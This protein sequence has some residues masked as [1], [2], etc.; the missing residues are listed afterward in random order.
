M[1]RC[2]PG[3]VNTHGKYLLAEVQTGGP[4]KSGLTPTIAYGPLP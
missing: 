1:H 4:L 3:G 2:C